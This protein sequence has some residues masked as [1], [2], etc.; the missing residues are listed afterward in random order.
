[1]KSNRKN[2]IKQSKEPEIWQP[3]PPKQAS[4]GNG[5]K[6]AGKRPGSGPR[7]QQT[8]G[9]N[10][11]RPGFRARWKK[12]TRKQKTTRILIAVGIVLAI[13]FLTGWMIW[14]S[15]MTNINLI[16]PE[17]ETV[18]EEYNIPTESLVHP[19]PEVK[20]VTNILLLGIDSR[21][22]ESLNE[23]SDAMMILTI[24][25]ENGK[26]KLTSLQ[27]DMLVYLPGKDKPQKINSANVAGGPA[28]AMRVV[29]DTFRLNIKN[30]VVVNMQAMEELI[31]IVGG[32]MIDVEPAEVSYINQGVADSN[33]FNTSKPPSSGIDGAGLQKLDGRQAVAYS[34]I[35]Y[36]GTDYARMSRQRTVLQAM[37]HS[38]ADASIAGK[39]N[40]ITEGLG[41]VSTNLKE[42]QIMEMGLKTLPM[43]STQIEQLQIP[44]D[45]F[46]REYSGNQWVNLCDFNG[47]IPYLQEFI[48]G[49]TFPFD[50]VKEIAGAPNS[51]LPFVET[52]ARPTTVETEETTVEET[53]TVEVTTTV[54]ETTTVATT[55][56]VTAATIEPTTDDGSEVTPTPAS[57]ATPTPAPDLTPTPMLTPTPALSPT[58][59]PTPA[60]AGGG[61]TTT[62]STSPQLDNGSEDNEEAA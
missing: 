46:F 34:R 39:T 50:K 62:T 43:M 60:A 15:M 32:V 30:Y 31:D 52:T 28:L 16:D 13:V 2:R 17:T 8:G 1:M 59:S 11:R 45:G 18:P 44:I 24:N 14:K 40:M 41:Y 35:R 36:I 26:I 53:T 20:G 23:R 48:W 47:M 5:R 27:R 22:R 58:P 37:L 21:S 25:E 54:T 42:S 29:N 12:L 49:K 56:A 3:I 51:S 61:G 6:P 38:F 7:N 9:K 10:R 33:A 4:R 55:T 57:E 19:V